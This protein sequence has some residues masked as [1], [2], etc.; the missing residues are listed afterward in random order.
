MPFLS[1]LADTNVIS[2]RLSGEATVKQWLDQHQGE[3][4]IS[5][6]TL[7]ELRRG[8]E[9]KPESKA[10]RQLGWA[11]KTRFADL[12]RLMVDADTKLLK[13]HREGRIKVAG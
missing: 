9:L 3:V 7:A 1:H 2:D 10:R 6:F 13:D 4:A 11:A 12:V 8:I 5:T